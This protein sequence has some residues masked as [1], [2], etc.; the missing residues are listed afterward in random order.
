MKYYNAV[1]GFDEIDMVGMQ[2]KKRVL[3]S[4]HYY[5]NK[6]NEVKQLIKN[7]FDVF[8]DSGAF[9]AKNSGEKINIDQYCEF[10]KFTQA[11]N[12]A[13][14]DVIGNAKATL[15]NHEY[16]IKEHNL[17][18]IPAFHMGSRIDDLKP[19]LD[20]NYIAL[21]GLVFSAGITSHCDEVWSYILK[22]KPSLKVH[23]FGLT[24]IELMA[25]YPWYSVDSSSFKSCKRFGRQNILWDGIN[26]ETFTEL[27]Y[28]QYLSELGVN[29]DNLDNKQKY[30]IY[31]YYSSVSY[32]IYAAHLTEINK[33]KN[34]NYLTIQQKL[35]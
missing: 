34:F 7:K 6:P 4:Y 17:N 19:L 22:N 16:M 5:K 27:E 3:C 29:F 11:I 18:P 24:N 30:K 1:T 28:Q 35:F 20:Y 25:R 9:S 10:L 13:T 8:I 12:Y 32:A 21:G 33:Y 26:F 23:G 14:L 15:N 2:P 31:D